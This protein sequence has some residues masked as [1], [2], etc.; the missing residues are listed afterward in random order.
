MTVAKKKPI[1]K[2]IKKPVAKKRITQ[3]PVRA[4][5]RKN[6]P[7]KA[8]A[9]PRKKNPLGKWVAYVGE[10]FPDT[11]KGKAD[12]LAFAKR[13]ADKHQVVTHVYKA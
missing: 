10:Q 1:V 7:V 6:S 4:T 5:G 11:V 13:F 9:A 8:K 2:R 3:K 12:C